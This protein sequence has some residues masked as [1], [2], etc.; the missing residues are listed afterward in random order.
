[1]RNINEDAG[2]SYNNLVNFI[3]INSSLDRH[4]IASFST[5]LEPYNLLK[6]IEYYW[7]VL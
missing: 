1:M 2:I 3:K 7:S 4:K 6:L 5:F